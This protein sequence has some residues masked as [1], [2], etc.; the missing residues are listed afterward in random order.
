[1]L[2]SHITSSTSIKSQ[3]D[4]VVDGAIGAEV[5]KPPEMKL[6]NLLGF[7]RKVELVR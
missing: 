2:R 7:L 3:A 5:V 4:E 1:M 6:C